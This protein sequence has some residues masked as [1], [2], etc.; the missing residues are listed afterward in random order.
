MAMVVAQGKDA[1][2]SVCLPKTRHLEKAGPVHTGTQRQLAIDQALDAQR[3]QQQREAVCHYET[4]VERC[5][6]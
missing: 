2:W 1:W 4:A 6:C 5:R 3:G